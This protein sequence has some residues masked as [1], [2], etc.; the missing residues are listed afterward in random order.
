MLRI[1]N[2]RKSFA[3]GP[4]MVDVLKGVNLEVG[5]GELL[6][7][8]GSSGCGKS[9]LMNILGFLDVPSS[10]KYILDNRDTSGLSDNELS[11]IRNRKIGF[12]FQQFNLL[13]KLTAL[14]NVC[15]PLVYRGVPEHKRMEQARMVLDQVG[16]GDRMGHKPTELSGGQQQRVAIARAIVGK[17]GLLLADEPTGALD[18]QTSDE[19]TRLFFRLN[20]EHGLTT[21]IITH[22]PALAR[23]C[24]RMVRMRDGVV[25]KN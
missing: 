6:S 25:V 13:P 7:I 19:V 12:V 24:A 21:V 11:D 3:L 23:K 14:Q 2:I 20:E 8:V 1:E 17:P 10:G 15:L 16:M 9:T 5:D 22:D 18:S 4:V